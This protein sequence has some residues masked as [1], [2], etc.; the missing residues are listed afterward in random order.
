MIRRLGVP[1]SKQGT[2][3]EIKHRLNLCH[4]SNSSKIQLAGETMGCAFAIR[5]SFLSAVGTNLSRVA[6]GW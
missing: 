4:E 2:D 1:V 5:R 3:Y 6:D